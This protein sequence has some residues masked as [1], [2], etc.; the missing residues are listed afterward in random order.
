MQGKGIKI[1]CARYRQDTVVW[2][3]CEYGNMGMRER[4]SEDASK[5]NYVQGKEGLTQKPKR[6]VGRVACK[7]W[8]A[9]VESMH[10]MITD[11]KRGRGPSF[12]PVI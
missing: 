4:E 2:L 12:N 10:D 9:M 11:S 1:V 8:S 3:Q 7:S 6:R 5:Q